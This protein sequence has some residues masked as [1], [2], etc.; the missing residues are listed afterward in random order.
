MNLPFLWGF[1]GRLDNREILLPRNPRKSSPESLSVEILSV[2]QGISLC[3]LTST[4][5]LVVG[6][7]FLIPHLH[8]DLRLCVK[9]GYVLGKTSCL[10][11]TL[12]WNLM[13]CPIIVLFL[14]L[15]QITTM[16]NHKNPKYVF[17]NIQ[18]IKMI[19]TA[20]EMAPSPLSGTFAAPSDR[21]QFVGHLPFI[22]WGYSMRTS[23][24]L[25]L[26]SSFLNLSWGHLPGV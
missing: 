6:Y 8:S 12:S 15:C 5:V 3:I 19:K 16:K 26:N 13:P 1:T 18:F 23:K 11:P 9:S 7:F 17:K 25:V 22:V 14:P 24:H 21:S 4:G 2:R 10:Q 20:T